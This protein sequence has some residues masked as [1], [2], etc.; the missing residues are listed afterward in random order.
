MA[1]PLKILA[2]QFKSLGD[3]VLVI[4]ALEAIRQHFPDCELHAFVSEGAAALLHGQPCLTRVWSVP[5]VHGHTKFR[6]NWP[7]VRA[8][9]AEKFDRSVDFGGNDR[10]ALLSFLCGAKQRLGIDRPKFLVRHLYFNQLVPPQPDRQPEAWR[11]MALLSPWGISPR[12]PEEIKIYADPARAAEAAKLLPDGAIVCHVGAGMPR[13][14]WPL[15]DWEAFGKMALAAGHRLMFT[16]GANEREK[17]EMAELRRRL[18]E[19]GM[20]PETMSVALF[21]AVL[22]RARALV[23]S[24][25]GPMHFAAALGTPVVAMFGPSNLARWAPVARNKRILTGDACDCDRNRHDCQRAKPCMAGIT[26]ERV[27]E[28]LQD[29]LRAI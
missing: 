20:L 27:L 21:L 17:A 1:K 24:D 13:K 29:I 28:N 7:V 3:T 2:I 15:A 6:E 11:S 18:P 25:T 16:P 8:L 10:G 19:A 5:R 23:T 4:P 22:K 14:Q 9:R 26:P 12:V